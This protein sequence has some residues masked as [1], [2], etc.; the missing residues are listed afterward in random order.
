MPTLLNLNLAILLVLLDDVVSLR[1]MKY[2]LSATDIIDK[3]ATDLPIYG[4]EVD[5]ELRFLPIMYMSPKF[6]KKQ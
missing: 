1:L 3:H 4:L 6:N 2:D 5:E